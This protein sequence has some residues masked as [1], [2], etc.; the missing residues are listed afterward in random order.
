LGPKTSSV[1]VHLV[2]GREVRDARPDLLDDAPDVRA[3]ND[4]GL[5]AQSIAAGPELG[6]YGV[7]ACGDP[8]QY[9]SWSRLG[10]LGVALLEAIRRP[11]LRRDHGPHVMSFPRSDSIVH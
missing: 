8:H 11:E 6:V 2:A 9:F 7:G 5:E 3:E 10:P 4:L 1:I